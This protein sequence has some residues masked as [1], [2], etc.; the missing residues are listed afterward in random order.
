M[1][2]HA[3]GHHARAER[4][5]LWPARNNVEQAG[6]AVIS[7]PRPTRSMAAWWWWCSERR[8][9]VR[10]SIDVTAAA[11]V[12]RGITRQPV[13]ESTTG[14]SGSGLRGRDETGVRNTVSTDIEMEMRE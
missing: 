13:T 9:R 1:E 8:R 5:Y 10:K 2:R 14:V 11:C 7:T 12:S 6:L 4:V 3:A